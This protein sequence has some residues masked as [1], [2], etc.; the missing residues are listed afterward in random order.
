LLAILEVSDG[1]ETITCYLCGKTL[2]FYKFIPIP[3][4]YDCL[5]PVPFKRAV[6]KNDKFCMYYRHD[7]MDLM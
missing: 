1:K 4:N 5:L 7:N 3:K 6:K 2:Y